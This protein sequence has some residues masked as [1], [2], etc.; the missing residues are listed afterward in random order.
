M[1][2]SVDREAPNADEQRFAANLQYLRESRGWSQT[3]LARQ[4]VAAGWDTY[5]QMTVSRT[6]KGERPIRLSEAR[7]L[8][9]I[10]DTSME[11]MVSESDQLRD[12]HRL[13]DA[14]LAVENSMGQIY[15]SCH[16]LYGNIEDVE[17]LI[18]GNPALVGLLRAENGTIL[19]NG[20]NYRA[21]LAS[22]I[23]RQVASNDPYFAGS[24]SDASTLAAVP[25]ALVG[26]SLSAQDESA[27]SG[28]NPRTI[29]DDVMDWL[30][31]DH[32]Y[33]DVPTESVHGES[34]A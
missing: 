27:S 11:R 10:M 30:H 15:S 31:P 20:G 12:H 19:S 13:L 2:E 22:E 7:A 24:E 23:A 25:A 29:A 1:I 5:N 3:E 18:E 21:W 26:L 6:E 4:M 32:A 33:R 28:E 34:D 9:N 17:D 14:H 16:A 8:A